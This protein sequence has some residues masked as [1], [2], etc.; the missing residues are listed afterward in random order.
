MT[1]AISNFYASI[2]V[3]DDFVE[4]VS[5]QAIARC[6]MTGSSAFPMSSARPQAVAEGRYKAVNMVGAGVIAAV[7]NALRRSRFRS[8]SAATARVSR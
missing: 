7:S 4:A 5:G 2:P 3:V 8:C 6:R 1:A